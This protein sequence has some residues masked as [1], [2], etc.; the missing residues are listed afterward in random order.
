[1][2]ETATAYDPALYKD[3]WDAMNA[4][5]G[6]ALINT[7]NNKWADQIRKE[8]GGTDAFNQHPINIVVADKL[9]QLAGIYTSDEKIQAAYDA[10]LNRCK[11]N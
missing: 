9:L 7:W 2:P 10:V 3:V 8:G 5:N 11:E 4:C 6:R 1:M